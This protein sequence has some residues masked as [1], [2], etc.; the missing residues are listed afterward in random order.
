MCIPLEIEE[1]VGLLL[2]I[3]LNLVIRIAVTTS[4]EIVEVETCAFFPLFLLGDALRFR[5]LG[6]VARLAPDVEVGDILEDVEV[7]VHFEF[8]G[9][10]YFFWLRDVVIVLLAFNLLKDI[11]VEIKRLHLLVLLRVLLPIHASTQLRRHLL[12]LLP[13]TSGIVLRCVHNDSQG[14]DETLFGVVEVRKGD[15]EIKDVDQLVSLVLDGFC[16]IDKVL[17][18]NK[19]FLHFGHVE[20]R[21]SLQN[22]SDVVIVDAVDFHQVLKQHEDQV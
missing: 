2:T 11:A 3:A 18:H 1:V 8:L 16:Q 7:F 22:L 4:R 20:S 15:W 14:V 13:C 5:R 21:E 10:I 12:H 19:R 6:L 17:V 9:W